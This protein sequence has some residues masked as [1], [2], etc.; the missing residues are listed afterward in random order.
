[1]NK[2]GNVTDI[3]YKQM[4]KDADIRQATNQMERLVLGEKGVGLL[5][6]LG[7]TPGKIQRHLDEEWDRAFEELLQEHKDYI[8]RES[9]KRS[10][11]D[12]EKWRKE[13]DDTETRFSVDDIIQKLQESQKSAE[14]EVV[15]ELVDQYL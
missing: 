4:D 9:R 15:K 12:V 8:F 13:M 5:D 3:K 1:M 2:G 6:H 14:M 7:L 11:E 10:A